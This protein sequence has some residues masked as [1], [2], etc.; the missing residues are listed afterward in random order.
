M[1]FW[2]V[3]SDE[4]DEVIEFFPTRRRAERMLAED[5]PQSGLRLLRRRTTTPEGTAQRQDSSMIL[6]SRKRRSGSAV[7]S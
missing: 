7:A 6:R 3:V 1:V 4:I 5:S 2:A